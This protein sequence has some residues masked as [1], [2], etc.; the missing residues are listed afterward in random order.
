VR[1][2]ALPI[3]LA[4]TLGGCS[5]AFTH[6]PPPGHEKL[7]EFNC[8]TSNVGPVLDLVVG[9]V[10]LINVVAAVTEQNDYETLNAPAVAGGFVG[11]AVFG[12]LAV[13]GFD[14]TAKCRSAKQQLAARK[15]EA[16]NAIVLDSLRVTPA[17]DSLSVGQAVALT[18]IVFGTGGTVKPPSPVR[19]SSSREGVAWVTSTGFV[20]ALAPGSAVITARASNA[21]GTA[22]VVG[23]ATILVTT[24]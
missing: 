13:V 23:T 18:A 20:T 8:T 1:A 7:P 4:L 15:A 6:G 3:G 12:S 17:A 21:E 24:P 2:A 16:Q 14:K 22:T 9:T 11:A 19:W 5:I 10:V